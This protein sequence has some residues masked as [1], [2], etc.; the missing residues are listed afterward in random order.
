MS[1][2]GDTLCHL[3]G[4]IS[5]HIE[6]RLGTKQELTTGRCLRRYRTGAQTEDNGLLTM[7]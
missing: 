7:G 2:M 6:E 4:D 3:A 5:S 1:P